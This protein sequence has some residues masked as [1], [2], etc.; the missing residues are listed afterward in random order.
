MPPVKKNRVKKETSVSTSSAAKQRLELIID[1]ARIIAKKKRD[2]TVAE[3]T[4]QEKKKKKVQIINNSCTC[5]QNMASSSK[6]IRVILVCN[7][8]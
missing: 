5:L 8:Q 4:L 7:K 3:K 1:T 6:S 2:I